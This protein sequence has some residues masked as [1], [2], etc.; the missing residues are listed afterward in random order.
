MSQDWV[1]DIE[2]FH[3]EV[4]LD[5]FET[6]PHIPDPK[7]K[8]LRRTLIREEIRE[9]LQAMQANNLTKIA[10]GIADSIVVLLGTAT[11][12]GI[13]MRP[14]WNEVHRTNM[15]KKTG[16]MREDGKRLKPEG[17]KPPNI[18]GLLAQQM[19]KVGDWNND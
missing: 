9:T 8:K 5:N 2:E 13:D 6:T 11:T 10:D 19:N 4:M 3:R 12:Y 17:W 15:E 7:Y 1:K 18:G 14:I 16:P